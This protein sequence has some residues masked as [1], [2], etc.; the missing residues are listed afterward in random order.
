MNS[1]ACFPCEIYHIIR[2]CLSYVNNDYLKLMNTSKSLFSSIK[3]ETIRLRCSTT[4]AKILSLIFQKVKDPLNQIYANVNIK[5]G[6][7]ENSYFDLDVQPSL[8]YFFKSGF[9]SLFLKAATFSPDSSL[10]IFRNIRE[11]NLIECCGF[12]SLTGLEDSAVETLSLVEISTLTDISQMKDMKKLKKVFIYY[13][14]DIEDM[15]PLYGIQN[16]K[17]KSSSIFFD[18]SVLGNHVSF[19][20]KFLHCDNVSVFKNIQ[21]LILACDTIDCDLT[22]LQEFTGSLTLDIGNNFVFPL[23]SFQGISLS[24]RKAHFIDSKTFFL[25]CQKL[26]N[27]SLTVC[28]GIDCLSMKIDAS[29]PFRKTLRDL[30]VCNCDE[31]KTISTLGFIPKVNVSFC[32]SLDTSLKGLG[33][34]ENGLRKLTLTFSAWRGSLNL[35]PLHGLYSVCLEENINFT[36]GSLLQNI[37]H[38]NINNSNSFNDTVILKN[39]YHVKLSACRS[40][41]SLDGLINVSVVELITCASLENIDNL[42]KDCHAKSVLIENCRVISDFEKDG[43]YEET[44]K[45]QIRIFTIRNS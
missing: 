28:S 25:N 44:L 17:I 2:S 39:I 41:V 23:T 43:Q 15:S 34:E 14:D 16:L 1:F 31:I 7:V 35:I 40:L 29:H 12:T 32:S 18:F 27:L 36:P 6:D 5:S 4:D 3:H 13:C 8:E 30:E 33:V 9:L 19:N 38:L 22:C 45:K 11:L 26:N 37:Q 10:L 42:I 20:G 24:L 21:N